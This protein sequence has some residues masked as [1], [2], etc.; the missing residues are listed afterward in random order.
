[1]IEPS[2]MVNLLGEK[3]HDGEAIYEGMEEVLKLSGV[4]VHLYG[5]KLTRSFRKMG[6]VTV[7]AETLEEAHQIAVQVKEI[8]KV[9]A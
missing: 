1:M 6:H 5:K 3:G 7:G 2:V 4:H 8:L 9:K